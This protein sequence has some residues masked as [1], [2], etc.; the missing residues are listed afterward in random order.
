MTTGATATTAGS[1]RGVAACGSGVFY[2]AMTVRF[3]EA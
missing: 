2:A 3:G 1:I